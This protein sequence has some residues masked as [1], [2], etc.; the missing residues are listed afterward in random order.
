MQWYE[1]G[2]Y[3][4]GILDKTMI[5]SSDNDCLLFEELYCVL[6]ELEVKLSEIEEVFKVLNSTNMR[7][8]R[9]KL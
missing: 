6:R 4:F 5:P 3:L 7:G 9:R 2:I 8:K 1:N